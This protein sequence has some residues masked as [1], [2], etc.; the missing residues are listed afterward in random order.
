M[1]MVLYQLSSGIIRKQMK[2]IERNKFLFSKSGSLNT[3]NF[4]DFITRWTKILWHIS[5][6]NR[7][8]NIETKA[9]YILQG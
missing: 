1:K 7:S 8:Q 3:K 5:D 4:E 9:F 6:D 2:E